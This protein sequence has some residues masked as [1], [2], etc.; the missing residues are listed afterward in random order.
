M[1][2]LGNLAVHTRIALAT[3]GA[4]AAGGALGVLLGEVVAPQQRALAMALGAVLAFV[5]A[6][7]VDRWLL[8]R[9]LR[10]L[11]MLAAAIE[12]A[13]VDGSALYR[14]L[15]ERGPAEVEAIVA[16]WNGFALRFDILVDSVRDASTRLNE[17]TREL[18]TTGPMA[19]R[20]ATQQRD[21]LQQLMALM[22][23]AT[24]ASSERA[25]P[26]EVDAGAS[27][28]AA[29]EHIAEIGAT[30]GALAAQLRQ[31]SASAA[32]ARQGLSEID[33][34]AY[35]TNLLAINASIEAAHAG[36]HGL[37][38]AV[39][40]DEVRAMAQRSAKAARHQHEQLGS[41]LA[42]AD[43][44]ERAL[45]A[46]HQQLGALLPLLSTTAAP[47]AVSPA[48]AAVDEALGTARAVAEK[49][50]ADAE[51]IARRTDEL[52]TAA[53]GAATAAAAVE[54]CVW[55]PPEVDNRDIVRLG[56]PLPGEPSIVA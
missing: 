31:L 4:A 19:A 5:V 51:A 21:A 45:E 38:F 46:L 16:A 48:A 30:L 44:G 52:A 10:T 15:P 6:F 24:S 3:A 36:Q 8:W 18:S 23:Q 40:A 53:K 42:A 49:L 43:A 1:F 12:D 27:A 32:A 17:R 28:A 20:R 39:V 41:S 22:Q 14:S 37:G 25:T 35:Q 2:H 56:E 55:P 9:E 13:E 50:L 34:V 47:D 33:Q 7:A 29:R 54:A 26:P 11:R